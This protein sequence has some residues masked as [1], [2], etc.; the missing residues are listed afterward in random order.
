M[1]LYITFL[2]L[3]KYIHLDKISYNLTYKKLYTHN[4]FI[5]KIDIYTI[6]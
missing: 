1:A 3:S 2:E 4:I 6:S 5:K